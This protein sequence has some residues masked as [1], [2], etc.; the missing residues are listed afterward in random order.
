MDNQRR[1]IGKMS[2]TTPKWTANSSE[3]AMAGHFSDFEPRLLLDAEQSCTMAKR[4]ASHTIGT[5]KDSPDS[6]RRSR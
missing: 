1:A 5:R 2:A 6:R 3:I 4:K